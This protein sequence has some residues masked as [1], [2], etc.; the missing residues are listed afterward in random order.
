MIAAAGGIRRAVEP[1]RRFFRRD[2]DRPPEQTAEQ[3]RLL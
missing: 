1:A 2:R 3:L